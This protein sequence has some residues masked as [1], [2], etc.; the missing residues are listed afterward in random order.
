MRALKKIALLVAIFIVAALNI[1]IYMNS[2]L[3]YRAS[4][5]EDS[6]GKIALLE[7]SNKFCPL[8]DLVFYELGKAY[9]DLSLMNLGDAAASESSFRKS[10]QNLRKSILINPA[11]PYSHFYLGQSLL[12]LDLFSSGRDTRFYDEFRRAAR[13]A[14]ENSHIF[15]EVGRLFLS[16]WPELSEE[17]RS[18][19]LDVLRKIMAKKDS[20]QIAV[21]LNIWELNAKDYQVM[22]KVLPPDAQTYRQYA[23]F[24]GEKS[25]SLEERHKCIAQAELLDFEKASQEYQSGETL[26]YHF[27]TQEAFS[28]FRLSQDLLGGIR[29]YQALNGKNLISSSETGELLKSTWLNLAKCRIEEG[30]GLNEVVDYLYQYLALEDR[31]AKVEEL[32]AYLRDRGVIPEKFSKS[33]GDLSRLS[34]ELLLQFKQTKYR[35]IINFGREL[36]GSFIVIPEAIKPDYVRILQLVGDSFK[37]VDFLYEASDIY[38]RALEIDPNNLEAWLAIRQNYDRLNEERKLAEINKAIEKLVTPKEVEF[39][40]LLLNKREMFSRALIFDGQKVILDLQFQTDEKT[41]A[42]LVAIFFNNRVVWEEFM[43]NRVISLNL[44]TNAGENMLQ[45][46]PINR[47]ISLVKLTYRLSDRN[48]NLGLLRR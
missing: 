13:L 17:D 31:A 20:E 11:S 26:L 16:R 32:A 46:S 40:N 38:Q 3:Y 24:L 9:L 22:D 30:A 5:V 34:F 14:G 7:R 4:R 25:L 36:Q 21:L 41:G 43:K 37:K 44:E 47:P 48:K 45:I 19:T 15:F 10:A 29:I 8:N 18:F 28:H 33:S 42:P 35:E 1:F 39:K 23:E 12:N 27:Q 6:K 2:H